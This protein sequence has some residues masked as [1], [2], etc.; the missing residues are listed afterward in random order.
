MKGETSAIESTSNILGICIGCCCID[1]Q[2][3]V[4]LEE[5][6]QVARN[7]ASEKRHRGGDGGGFRG[8]S[9]L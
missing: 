8:G 3:W 1:V 5:G 2:T 7:S 9:M 6:A 4:E